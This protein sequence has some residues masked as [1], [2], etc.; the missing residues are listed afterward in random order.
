MPFIYTSWAQIFT[1]LVFYDKIKQFFMP[2]DY[3]KYSGFEYYGKSCFSAII[4]M[5]L[6][7]GFVYPL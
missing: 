5:T 4:C 1:K 3:S 6:S 2:F 7:F